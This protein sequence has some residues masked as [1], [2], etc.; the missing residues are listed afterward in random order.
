MTAWLDFDVASPDEL[1]G[2][3]ETPRDWLMQEFAMS[4][5]RADRAKLALVF[6]RSA[7][8]SRNLKL[9]NQARELASD[10]RQ[11]NLPAPQR[12]EGLRGIRVFRDETVRSFRLARIIQEPAS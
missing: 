7:S 2:F 8:D 1:R 6:L 10:I 12:R 9:A 11:L 5:T 4:A 3:I